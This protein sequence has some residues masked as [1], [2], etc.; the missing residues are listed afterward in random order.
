MLIYEDVAIIE[1]TVSGQGAE[2]RRVVSDG[3]CHIRLLS[4]ER[5][6]CSAA[7]FTGTDADELLDLAAAVPIETVE[8]TI[9][10]T[11]N[12]THITRSRAITSASRDVLDRHVGV[13]SDSRSEPSMQLASSLSHGTSDCVE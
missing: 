10:A 9:R 5:H 11:C 12:Y 8:A 3:G 6:L 4:R 13:R 1:V 7:N 2:A